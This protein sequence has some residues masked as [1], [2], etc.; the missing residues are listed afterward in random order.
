MDR[1]TAT[2]NSAQKC[3]TPNAQPQGMFEQLNLRK[4]SVS[5]CKAR[6]CLLACASGPDFNMSEK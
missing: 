5:A 2:N 3:P 4:I 6:L 1:L